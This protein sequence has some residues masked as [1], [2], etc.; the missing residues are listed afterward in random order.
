VTAEDVG[1][2]ETA[3]GVTLPSGYRDLLTSHVAVLEAAGTTLQHYAVLW[4]APDEIIQGNLEARTYA[5]DMA[6]GE[7]EDDERPW[8]A[9]YLL[10]GT[11]GGGDYWFLDVHQE[12]P[13]LCF[14]QHESHQVTEYA[15][16][17][18]DYLARVR[19]DLTQPDLWPWQ[20]R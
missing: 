12:N 1:R 15:A 18:K 17:L 10:V 6:I 11:N 4:T 8:P 5:A 3:L 2:I 9:S 16:S 20:R 7:D 13:P 19:Q 14:W